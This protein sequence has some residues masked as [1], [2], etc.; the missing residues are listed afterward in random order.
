MNTYR[1]IHTDEILLS[2]SSESRQGES[3]CYG[4]QQAG[5]YR[6]SVWKFYR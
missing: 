4:G 5:Q 3:L 2:N 1:L 6:Q